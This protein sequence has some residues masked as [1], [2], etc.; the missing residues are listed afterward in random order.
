MPA[1]ALGPAELPAWGCCAPLAKFDGPAEVPPGSPG[2][3][4]ATAALVP[5]LP[6]LAL[7]KV[8]ALAGPWPLC[9]L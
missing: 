8:R 6:G 5:M 2:S 1:A 3:T 4:C 7:G 9:G